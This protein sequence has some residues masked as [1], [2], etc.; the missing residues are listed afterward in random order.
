MTSKSRG[1]I[2]ID[3]RAKLKKNSMNKGPIAKCENFKEQIEIS[4]I[5]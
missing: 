2:A 4:H 5:N 1:P 3:S